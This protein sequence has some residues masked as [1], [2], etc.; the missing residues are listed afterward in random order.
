MT[1]LTGKI[2]TMIKETFDI[3]CTWNLGVIKLVFRVDDGAF[4]LHRKV[5]Y[6]YDSEYQDL[7]MKIAVALCQ[8]HITIHEALIF[9]QEV[10]L[11]IH[12]APSGM[13]LRDM[14]GRLLL[15]PLESATCAVIFFGG[16]WMDAAVAA[17]CG[18][19]AGRCDHC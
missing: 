12:T 15:Y 2:L 11:G 14:P 16:D 1:L 10:K 3:R 6:D 7:Y 8:E 19:A 9:Q 18:L 4:E 13:F 17:I 5:P